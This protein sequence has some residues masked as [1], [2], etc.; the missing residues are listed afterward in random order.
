MR[1]LAIAGSLFAACCLGVAENPPPAGTTKFIL[2]GNRM[3]AELAFVRP[4]GS[5]H[6]ALAFVDMGSASLD[7]REPLFAELEVARGKPVTFR[8]GEMPIEV[9]PDLVRRDP[10]T[11]RSLGSELKVEALLPAEHQ[12]KIARAGTSPMSL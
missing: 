6:R 11:P 4:D 10:S 7:L 2:D 9:P 3:Y 1:V 8:I 12:R 5:L